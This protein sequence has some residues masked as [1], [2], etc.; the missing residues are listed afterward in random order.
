[1]LFLDLG[2]SKNDSIQSKNIYIKN[3][4]PFRYEKNILNTDDFQRIW[5]LDD[6]LGNPRGHLKSTHTKKSQ[7]REHRT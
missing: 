4:I 2:Q 1:M 5:Y 6:T 3:I 7:R